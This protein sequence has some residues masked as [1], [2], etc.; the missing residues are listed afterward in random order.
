VAAAT[1]NDSLATLARRYVTW[2]YDLADRVLV[3]TE[4]YRRELVDT[5]LAASKIEILERGVDTALFHSGRR[6]PG[7]YDAVLNPQSSTDGPSSTAGSEAGV[8][9]RV[10]YVGRLAPEKNLAFLL[11]ELQPLLGMRGDVE[12]VLVGDGPSRHELAAWA[13][14]GVRFLG[15]LHGEALATAY[16]SADLFVFPSTTDTFG[17]VVLEAQACGLP[18]VVTNEGGPRELVMPG[19]TGL[20]VDI[21]REGAF[22]AAVERLLDDP[23]LRRAMGRRAQVHARSHTWNSVL[24]QLWYGQD[25]RPSEAAAV[26]S[27]REAGQS[28]ATP[29]RTAAVVG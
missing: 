29:S 28:G 18:V 2:F 6:E 8:P 9:L 14:D 4:V 17:N 13:G 24:D 1:D 15:E 5:G 20:V 3:P 25:V 10:L 22:V 19:L 26:S 12:L 11:R 27:L 21:A 23:E 7:F 16:A